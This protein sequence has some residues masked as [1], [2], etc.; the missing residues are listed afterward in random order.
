[1]DDYMSGTD[2]GCQDSKGQD[3]SIQ[4]FQ[5]REEMATRLAVVRDW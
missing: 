3:G 5:K 2:P 1:M 4:A